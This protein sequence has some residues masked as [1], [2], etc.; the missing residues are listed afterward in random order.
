MGSGSL[1]Q[2]TIERLLPLIPLERLAV[3]TSTAQADII[4]LDLYRH[5]WYDLKLWLEHQGR[6]TAPAVALAATFLET[7]VE[8]TILGVFPADHNIDDCV[9]SQKITFSLRLSIT[10]YFICHCFA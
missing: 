8:F 4:K 7:E 9:K 6:N 3:V 10:T 2:A 5:G 1:L